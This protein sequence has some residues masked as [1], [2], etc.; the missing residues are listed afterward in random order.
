[1]WWPKPWPSEVERDEQQQQ[2]AYHCVNDPYRSRSLIFRLVLYFAPLLLLTL[3]VPTKTPWF[4]HSQ[5][6]GHEK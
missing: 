6:R 5:S 2:N 1:M 4:V 3:A